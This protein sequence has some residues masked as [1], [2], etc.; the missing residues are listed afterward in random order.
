MTATT[1]VNQKHVLLYEP[2]TEG[3]HITWLRFI[4]EDLLSAGVRLT[5]A[6]DQRPKPFEKIQGHLAEL[7]L[8]V[9]CINATGPTGTP[10]NKT[11]AVAAC[12]R[13][14]GADFVFLCALDEIASDIWR[15]ASL[16]WK[17]PLGLR[18]RMGGIYH[19]PRFFSASDWSPQR[20]FKMLGFRRLLG[21][22]WLRQ[23][24]LLDEFLAAEVKLQF[25]QA[26]VFAL[27]CPCLPMA[28]PPSALARQELG[29]PADRH[30][31]LFYGGGYRRKGLHLA[32][33]AMLDV[34][35]KSP[36]FLLCVG[37]QNPTGE[38]ASG[39]DKLVRQ[40]RAL[41]LNRYVTTAEEQLS[42]AACD[43]VLLPYIHHFGASAVLAQA[44][45]ARR[46]VIVSDEEL[47]GRLTSN[48][49]LGL[50]FTPDDSKALRLKM[51]EAIQL[52]PGNLERFKVAAE[53]FARLC[54]RETYRR[55]LLNAILH[56]ELPPTGLP[57]H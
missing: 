12:L 3:H 1:P 44:A 6:V 11:A 41:L 13:Q 35:P 19:R 53:V 45:A 4:I 42:F 38:V 36:A 48:H 46:M 54:S 21:Q 34:S 33:E 5:L 15:K 43:T 23:L 27:P 55:I 50:L 17:P 37:Q 39:L 18:G 51:Q 32:V 49:G 16:G 25:P 8:Q 22:G 2:R 57:S 10:K 20:W 56:P 7:L 28:L 30:V 29:V 40:N 26:P 47:M 52:P 31:F 9:E 24:V 14:S